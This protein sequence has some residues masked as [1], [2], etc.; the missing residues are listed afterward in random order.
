MKTSARNRECPLP[1]LRQT[2]QHNCHVADALYAGDYT[3]CIY[4]LKM[5]EFYRWESGLPYNCTLENESVGRWL[6]MREELWEDL[7]SA[8][9]EEVRIE[10]EH[11]DPFDSDAINLAL[12]PFGLVYSGGLGLKAKPHFFLGK[13]HDH[14]SL[15]D[16]TVYISSDEYARD[17]TAPPAMALGRTIF[18]RRESLKRMVWEKLEEW[19]WNRPEN[20]MSRAIAHYDF[21]TSVDNALDEMTENELNSALLHEIGEIEAGKYLG[22]EWEHML[23][24]IP[25]SKAEIMLRALRDHIADMLSTLPA[26][27]EQEQ[28]ASLHFYFANLNSMRKHLYPSLQHAYQHWHEQKDLKPLVK[29][30]EL[31]RDHWQSLADNALELYRERGIEARDAI[32]SLLEDSRL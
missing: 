22:E 8:G 14:H 5:R 28:T 11:F 10:S 29:Q 18:L 25:H 15:D 4:L 27:V 24:Q 23:V 13:L 31:G 26:L 2:V 32:E 1:E 21:A 20:A 9:F 30:L 6:R 3:L 17:L 16:Y 7:E 19:R 12:Q